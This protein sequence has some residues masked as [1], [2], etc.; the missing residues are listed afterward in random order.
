MCRNYIA[1]QLFFYVASPGLQQSYIV[2]LKHVWVSAKV[3]HV[4][5][6]IAEPPPPIKTFSWCLLDVSPLY[7]EQF[8]PKKLEVVQ[9]IDIYLD[10]S[11]LYC[12][13][14]FFTSQSMLALTGIN[15]LVD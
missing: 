14:V 8:F 2:G 1:T 10:R 6:K 9:T 12:V 3:I 13:C 7:L 15:S 4:I 11:S 5:S